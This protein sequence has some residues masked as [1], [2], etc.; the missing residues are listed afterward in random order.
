M[1]VSPLLS[2]SQ[3][4]YLAEDVIKRQHAPVGEKLLPGQLERVFGI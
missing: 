1:A 2:G 3:T 4:F